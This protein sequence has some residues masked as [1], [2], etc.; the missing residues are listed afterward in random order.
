MIKKIGVPQK[1][2]EIAKNEEEFNQLKERVAKANDLVRCLS[3]GKLLAKRS[4]EVV[5]IK[6]KDLNVI[7]QKGT[8]MVDCPVCRT[9][10]IIN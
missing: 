8:I 9:K 7:A 4:G 6:R 10:N 2:N 1:I 3:C 5:D